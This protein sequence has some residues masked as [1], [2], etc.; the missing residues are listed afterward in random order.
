[1]AKRGAWV[2]GLLALLIAGCSAAPLRPGPGTRESGRENLVRFVC[3]RALMAYY[4]GDDERMRDSLE[5]AAELS[6]NAPQTAQLARDAS[7]NLARFEAYTDF[8]GYPRKR[9]QHGAAFR[10]AT[11]PVWGFP[12]DL[13]GA[14]LK[15]FRAVHRISEAR[16]SKPVAAAEGA[17]GGPETGKKAAARA[18]PRGKGSEPHGEA[19]KA[20]NS[21][22]QAR[23]KFS[24][25]S[26]SGDVRGEVAA[27]AVIAVLVLFEEAEEASG[28]DEPFY[29]NDPV[30]NWM[31]GLIESPFFAHARGI[32]V[33]DKL[34]YGVYEEVRDFVNSG[35]PLQVRNERLARLNDALDR[36]PA[37]ASR[38]DAAEA[39]A[40][41]MR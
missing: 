29:R 4:K 36:L 27:L 20:D 13:A 24:H 26:G 35:I 8:P 1:M 40:A 28:P 37:G 10:A 6:H 11:Y 34:S 33:R 7:A 18:S 12:C 38:S 9:I 5:L 21:P 22:R 25:G 39:L 19:L 31:R 23:A 16:A 3:N 32:V 14:S 41:E 15:V 2:A 30:E 17:K